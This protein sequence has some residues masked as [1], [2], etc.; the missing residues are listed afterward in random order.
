M[1]GIQVREKNPAQASDMGMRENREP[2]F[3]PKRFF[4][5]GVDHSCFRRT[6]RARDESC[7]TL[8]DVQLK[9]KGGDVA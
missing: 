1:I 5:T 8:T 9:N 4:R 3:G 7:V 6:S 2:I